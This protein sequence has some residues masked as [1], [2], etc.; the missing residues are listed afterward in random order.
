MELRE[1]EMGKEAVQTK[2]T[3]YRRILRGYTSNSTAP[4]QSVRA[5]NTFHSQFLY[6]TELFRIL[7]SSKNTL[8]MALIINNALFS[9]A[10]TEGTIDTSLLKV[11]LQNELFH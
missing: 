1:R 2:E 8:Y 11:T 10:L 4:L 9:I 5:V 3:A 7:S 6:F